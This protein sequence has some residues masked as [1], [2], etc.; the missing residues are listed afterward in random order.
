MIYKYSVENFYS[1]SKKIEIN[2]EA[3]RTKKDNS[4][5]YIDA[6]LGKKI[7]KATFIGGPNASGKTNILR[8]LAFIRLL[9]TCERN[10]D[11]I[12]FFPFFAT[13]E[14]ET[15]L[16]V[17]FSCDKDAVYEYFI[18]LNQN[19]ILYEKLNIKS[20]KNERTTSTKICERVWDENAR[21]YT[22]KAS[23]KYL[24]IA[25][26]MTTMNEALDNHV[27]TSMIVFISNFEPKDGIFTRI[28]QYWTKIG[29][30][31]QMLGSSEINH[32]MSKLA[33]SALHDL[34]EDTALRMKVIEVL[35][36]YDMD[37]SEI[38]KIINTGPNRDKTIY[39]L[40]HKITNKDLYCTT[41]FESSGTQ[42]LLILL[43]TILAVLNTGGVAIIDELDAFLHPNVYTEVIDLFTSI[44]ENSNNAQI[45]FSSQNY[46]ALSF[47]EK[48]QII[49]AEKGRNGN[50]HAWRLD[51]IDGIRPDENFFAKYL[52]GAYGA[53]PGV[54]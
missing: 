8:A 46:S 42:K 41:E 32:S 48:D 53:I 31:V 21:H 49:L 16:S 14:K 30:N 23:Y 13:P 19:K 6:P 39:S 9:L 27:N 20:H 40:H 36:K 5:L 17:A 51:D 47:L 25:K 28:R 22:I 54:K 3:K 50:T 4:E 45:I 34:Y 7:S 10:N 52:A 29:T 12:S 15:R 11:E 33:N 37:I 43:K 2:F 38:K 18:R 1:I 24:P 44:V 35:K 26:I